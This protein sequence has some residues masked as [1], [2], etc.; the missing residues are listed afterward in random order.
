MKKRILS[1]IQPSG[2]PHLGNYLGAMKNHIA[3]QN[4][5]DSFIF[6]ADLHAL[7]TV[8]DAKKLHELSLE[9][10]IDYLALG[11]DPEKTVFFRQ[12]DV[13]DHSEL[14]WI[15][16]CIT[17]MG[18]LERAHAYK[19]AVAKKAKDQTAGLFTYPVLMAAD[20][21]MYRPDLVPV[22]KDQKQHIEIARDIAVKFNET[23]GET[24]QL[25]E[26]HIPEQ[27]AVIMGTDGERKMSKSYGNVIEIF[28]DEATL[29]KQVMSIKTDSAGVQDPKDPQKSAIYNLYAHI[30]TPSE[31]K[32]FATKF[33]RGG[34]GYGDAKKILLEKLL[35]YFSSARKKRFELQKD[36]GYVTKVLKKGAESAQKEA[37]A[38]MAQVRAKTGLSLKN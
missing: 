23:F 5:Y 33:K 37:S 16:G 18:L 26:P 3:M 21:L 11:L 19:D 7:T 9:L 10:A 30:A 24:F 29:K 22:G 35:D 6:I 31:E 8:R 20:I 38:T 4:E 32:V 34:M 17:P 15:L 12:S 27:V 14:A 25:P 2:N 36:L 13:A 28:A 1:G